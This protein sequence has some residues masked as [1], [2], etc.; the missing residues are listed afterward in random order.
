M[1]RHV[2]KICSVVVVCLLVAPYAAGHPGGK[3]KPKPKPKSKPAPGSDIEK[4]RSYCSMN[5]K[6]DDISLS[7]PEA[8][9]A[10]SVC[11]PTA[12]SIVAAV[13]SYDVAAAMQ[14]SADLDIRCVKE[15]VGTEQSC[16]TTHTN[17]DCSAGG[18]C[19]ATPLPV[20][21]SDCV[22]DCNDLTGLLAPSPELA[23]EESNFEE[24]SFHVFYIMYAGL[25]VIAAA[26]LVY[27]LV[28]TRNGNGESFD[29]LPVESEMVYIGR[30]QE[31]EPEQ[32]QEKSF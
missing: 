32:S 6:R 1:L 13:G 15:V 20:C 31:A 30:I 2:F 18:I 5:F 12:Q 25:A 3:S 14:S 19:I 21:L 26:L 11:L 24:D 28:R 7:A 22:G 29:A 10:G 27:G 23:N 8:C 16:D 17:S 4:D 9:D